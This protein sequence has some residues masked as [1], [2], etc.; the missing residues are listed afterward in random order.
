MSNFEIAGIWEERRRVALVA[1]ETLDGVGTV[2]HRLSERRAFARGYL[3]RSRWDE[4]AG[5]S[6]H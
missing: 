2:T 4:R 5:I 3:R 6:L 1:E